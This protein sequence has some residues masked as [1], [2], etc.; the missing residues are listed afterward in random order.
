[1]KA[2]IKQAL[3]KA[4]G[5]PL[6]RAEIKKID[7]VA[8]SSIHKTWQLTMLDGQQLFAK[9]CAA[10]DFQRLKFEAEG[11]RSLN[12][13]T[14]KDLI[15]VPEPLLLTRLDN[16]SL[17]LLPWLEIEKGNQKNLGEGLAL[18][19]KSSAEQ[20]PDKY[21]WEEN[22]FIGLGSQKGGWKQKWG[23]CFVQ[24]RL[25]PQLEIAKKMAI[26]L[27]D[28]GDFFNELSHFLESHNP[29]PSLVHGDLWS[30]N[31]GIQ[32][33]GKAVIFDPAIWW[34]DREV[35]IAMTRLFGGF[36]KEFYMAY[37]SKWPLSQSAKDR[38][39]VYNLYHLINHANIFGGSYI[40]QS[41]KDLY[42]LKNIVK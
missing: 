12:N 32:K 40:N 16:L 35:D 36:T 18:L 39:K 30:G 5:S 19:H 3:Q 4:K 38:I 22:G 20:S 21:G 24:L 1:M 9:T 17:L 27:S 10:E 6:L 23:E 15:T 33:D 31:A 37:E 13:F 7:F 14:N 11:L 29:I 2:L 42:A 8:G 28:W 41:I 34:A 25:I 26:N